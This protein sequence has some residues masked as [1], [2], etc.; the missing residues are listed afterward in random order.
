MGKRNT[1]VRLEHVIQALHEEDELRQLAYGAGLTPKPGRPPL[2]LLHRLWN[3]ARPVLESLVTLDMS[4]AWEEFRAG[5][6]PGFEE[7]L[8]EQRLTGYDIAGRIL[9]R[10]YYE[11]ML[12]IAENPGSGLTDKDLDIVL[13]ALE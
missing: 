1:K 4:A 6:E 2:P 13:E 11:E 9:A 3:M 7:L 12:A 8:A 10:G 5:M